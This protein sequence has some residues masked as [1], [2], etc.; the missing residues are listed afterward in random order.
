MVS[1]DDEVTRP[2]LRRQVLRHDGSRAIGLRVFCARTGQ[3]ISLDACRK[4]A[5]YIDEGGGETA[6]GSSRIRCHADPEI[7][8]RVETPIGTVGEVLRLGPECIRED[9]P[10]EMLR[11]ELHDREEVLVVNR[12]MRLVGIVRGLHLFRQTVIQ[13]QPAKVLA[14]H[15]MVPP[16]AVPENA[17]LRDALYQMAHSHLRSVP[18]ITSSGVPLGVLTDIDAI[19]AI[20]WGRRLG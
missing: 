7:S 12:S 16:V 19:H 17:S 20:V 13:R 2:I 6:C 9:V 11:S 10:A 8:R 3:S 1:D 18:V 14:E 5:A 15:I 4:C